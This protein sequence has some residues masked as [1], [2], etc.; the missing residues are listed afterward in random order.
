MLLKRGSEND[1]IR[2]VRIIARILTGILDD[3]LPYQ[4]RFLS[5]ILAGILLY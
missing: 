5:R 2:V 4:K 3:W 1:K